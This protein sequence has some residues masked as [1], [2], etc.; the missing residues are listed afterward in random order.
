VIKDFISKLPGVTTQN[1]LNV[2]NKGQSLT[3]MLTMS[4]QELQNLTGNSTDAE[5]LYNALHKKLKPSNEFT[6]KPQSSKG[7]R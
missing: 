4:L 6:V 7:F 3:N 1:I 2:L 5:T